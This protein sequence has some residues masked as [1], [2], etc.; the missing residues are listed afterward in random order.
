MSLTLIPP[1]AGPCDIAMPSA[2][3]TDRLTGA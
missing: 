3:K 2:S 1:L